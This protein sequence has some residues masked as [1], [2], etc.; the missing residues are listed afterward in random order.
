VC[1]P[2]GFSK[3]RRILYF[4]TPG[5]TN[6]NRPAPVAVFIN[7]WMAANLSSLADP[8][9]GNFEDWI[10]LFNAGTN[11]ASLAGF[12]LT[13]DLA[14][15]AKYVFPTGTV[16]PARGYLLVWADEEGTQTQIHGD[17]HASFKL[18]QGGEIIA[19]HDD[20]GRLLD[21]V[22]FGPQTNN[23]SEGRASD[24]A[25]VPFAVFTIPTP[26]AANIII[27]TAP[28]R[29]ETSSLAV[30][31]G[32]FTFQWPTQPGGAYRVQFK[33]SLESSNWLDLLDI[34]TAGPTASATDTNRAASPQR[35]Y[36]LLW[37]P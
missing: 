10:E 18:A 11:A 30:T 36:R 25:A 21:L 31:P 23:L 1:V 8:A 26:R 12:T 15:P 22:N 29:L 20:G 33:N 16:I 17:L 19:L 24:G 6:D 9:D 4:A 5:G 37:L 27:P 34:P 14:A 35:F 13:D 2:D 32:T 3:D 28:L 7:E